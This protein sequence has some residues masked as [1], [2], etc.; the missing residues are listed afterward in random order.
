MSPMIDINLDDTPDR[1]EPIEVG[2]RVLTVV[3]IEE[4]TDKNGD[5]VHVVQLKVNEPDAPDHERMGWERFNFKYA[6]ARV[7]FKQFIK[8]CG[9][10]GSGAGVD[11]TE[12][13]GCDCK[14]VVASRNY[15]DKDSG[16]QVTTTQVKKFLFEA[17]DV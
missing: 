2:I 17:D 13:I 1:I 15:T 14:A 12:L 9:H 4:Q 6:P 8:S 10:D 11:T 5:V 16:D 7:K 3:D